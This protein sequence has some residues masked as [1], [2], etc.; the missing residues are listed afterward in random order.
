MRFC[1]PPSLRLVAPVIYLYITRHAM[2]CFFVHLTQ[3]CVMHHVEVYYL[4][5]FCV[6]VVLAVLLRKSAAA[7]FLGPEKACQTARIRRT[8][9]TSVGCII[10]HFTPLKHANHTKM[11]NCYA[12]TE[13]GTKI[14]ISR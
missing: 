14:T 10:V 5:V 1:F 7:A 12:A 8:Y 6:P 13:L 9:T 4:L 3:L 11:Q 2:F